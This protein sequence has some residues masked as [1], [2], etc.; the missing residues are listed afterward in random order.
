LTADSL[1]ASLSNAQIIYVDGGNTF[2]LQKYIYTTKF[3]HIV[4][5]HLESGTLYIGSSA[6]AIVAGK[7]IATAYWKGW[8]DPQVAEGMVWDGD[9]LSGASLGD[10]S[11]FPHYDS[12]A[13]DDLINSRKVDLD[14]DVLSLAND[15]VAVQMPCSVQGSRVNKMKILHI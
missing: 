15:E 14:H 9:T 10:Y 13:H 4:K 5:P 3:W 11:V 8:D 6:G 1:K 7:T 12:E 2:Y